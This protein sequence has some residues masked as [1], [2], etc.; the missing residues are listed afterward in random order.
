MDHSI[1]MDENRIRNIIAEDDKDGLATFLESSL[2]KL[3]AWI[4]KYRAVHCGSAL[5]EG[6]TDLKL[7]LNVLTNQGAFVLHEAAASLSA[8][9]IELFLRHGAQADVRCKSLDSEHNGLLPLQVALERVRYNKN[10]I[11]WDRQ[12]SIFKLI[13]ILCLPEMKEALEA[14]RLLACNTKMIKEVSYYYA[15]NFKV[16]EL[17]VLL[18]VAGDEI[19]DANL[20]GKMIAEANLPGASL[21]DAN[22]PR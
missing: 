16:I 15:T 1:S 3:L 4:C 8:P 22:L 11:L 6:K 14:I 7:N 13:I 2:V 9:L 5:L 18:M 12:K 10:L 20:P 17:A 19:P 21:A